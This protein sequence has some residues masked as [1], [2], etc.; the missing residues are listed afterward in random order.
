MEASSLL[1]RYRR[2]RRHLL[3]FVL[4]SGLP[5]DAPTAASAPISDADL[6]RLSTDY[7]L[8]CVKSG[9]AFDVSEAA[10]NRVDE[11]AYPVMIASELGDS[12]FLMTDIYLAGSP[13]QRLPPP[14]VVNQTSNHKPFSSGRF[15]S[16]VRESTAMDGKSYGRE[17]VLPTE[18]LSKIVDDVE[19]SSLG[20]P[21]FKTGLTDDD[22]REAAYEVLLAA[23]VFSG[24]EVYSVE[25]RKKERST[26]L[27][28]R[29]K[30]KMDR[31]PLQSQDF[32]RHLKITD[33][34][35]VQMQ[36][37]F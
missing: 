12:Y 14:V 29:V 13:P 27:L 6:D 26:K 9:R 2:D 1:E 8:D 15:D 28:S 33:V 24:I 17:C 30:S 10:R 3:R 11:S 7:V 34:I 22:L 23:M 5:I 35:R 37:D 20:L 21:S 31:A 18:D 19:F 36:L 16:L 32:E 25:Y 4:S